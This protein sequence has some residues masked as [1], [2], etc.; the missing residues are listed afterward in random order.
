M[1]EFNPP[2]FTPPS[3]HTRPDAGG[4]AQDFTPSGYQYGNVAPIEKHAVSV[5]ATNPLG[6]PWSLLLSGVLFVVAGG[7]AAWQLW[8]TAS[9][10]PEEVGGAFWI[11]VYVEAA[12]LVALLA[13]VYL[14]LAGQSWAR[15]VLTAYSVVW[16][17]AIITEGM[18]PASL[19]GILAAVLMWLPVNRRWFG[20]LS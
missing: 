19:L 6:A 8:E 20:F 2:E 1:P 9:A 10:A 13:F 4:G 15:W 17:L 5:R 18:W 3:N 12:T 7:W 16:L 14:M 11:S